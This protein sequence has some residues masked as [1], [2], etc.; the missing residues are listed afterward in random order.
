MLMFLKE[1][2]PSMRRNSSHMTQ[3]YRVI[4]V[5]TSPQA[6]PSSAVADDMPRAL[7]TQDTSFPL[8][9]SFRTPVP[10]LLPRQ[11]SKHAR[12]LLL[13]LLLLRLHHT[14]ALVRH[15]AP[16]ALLVQ[17][18][19][20]AASHR[21]LA[22]T[23]ARPVGFVGICRRSGRLIGCRCVLVSDRATFGER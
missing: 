13:P 15:V 12:R 3:M 20:Y 9:D 2:I 23:T 22:G 21:S 10:T 16:R 17:H 7:F 4:I 14:R 19:L 1:L 6:A 11:K 18:Y 8:F 5:S